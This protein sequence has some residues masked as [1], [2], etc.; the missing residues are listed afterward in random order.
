M[1]GSKQPD[2]VTIMSIPNVSIMC[3]V[4]CAQSSDVGAWSPSGRIACRTRYTRVRVR[5]NAPRVNVRAPCTRS[6]TVCRTRNT[7]TAVRPHAPDGCV[8]RVC[9]C[10]RRRPCIV[11]ICTAVRVCADA[12]CVDEDRPFAHTSSDTHYI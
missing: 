1:K 7:R 4:V 8:D 11:R 10:R 2:N 3:A 12:E 6:R 9:N 5:S